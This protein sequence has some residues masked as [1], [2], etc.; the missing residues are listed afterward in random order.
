MKP[1]TH[2]P[3]IL[4]TGVQ[5]GLW[6]LRTVQE[7][8]QNAKGV[9]YV[10]P[11]KIIQLP[12]QEINAILPYKMEEAS[13]KLL[14]YFN[15]IKE[16][17]AQPFILANITLHEVFNYYSSE[18]LKQTQC[19]SIQEIV[20][21]KLPIFPKKIVILGTK[22]TMNSGYFESFIP[23][24]HEVIPL[25]SSFQKKVDDLRISFYNKVDKNKAVEVYTDLTNTHPEIDLFIIACTELAVALE[26]FENK[27]KFF[28]LPKVQCELLVK[29]YFNSF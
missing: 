20:V 6:Y 5:S 7:V 28:N 15:E 25:N 4:L 22:Y 26:C 19:I 11:L 1:L 10:F 12:F 9:D 16:I 23:K 13:E 14:P 27:T 29:H 17:N 3:G 8:A 24:Q 18:F 2:F 21:R